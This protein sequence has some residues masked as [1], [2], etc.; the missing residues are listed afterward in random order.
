MIFGLAQRFKNLAL[1]VPVGGSV[2]ANLTRNHENAGSIPI[3]AQR[4]KDP[5]LLLA[6]V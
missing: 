6:V 3:L 4:V 5:V 1:G 2:E